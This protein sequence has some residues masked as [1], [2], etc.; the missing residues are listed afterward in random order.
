MSD[1]PERAF[2]PPPPTATVTFSK[3]GGWI[4]PAPMPAVTQVQVVQPAV[5][6]QPLPTGQPTVPPTTPGTPPVKTVEIVKPADDIQLYANDAL[7]TIV[8]PKPN[9]S[10]RYI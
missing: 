3:M 5:P 7:G 2:A 9:R 8:I 10:R 4:E 6:V 1:I